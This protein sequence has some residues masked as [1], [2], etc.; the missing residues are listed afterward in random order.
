[1]WHY[2]RS[3]LRSIGLR[4]VFAGWSLSLIKDSFGCGIF[5]STFEYIKSQSYYHFIDRYYGHLDSSV[6][7]EPRIFR[8]VLQVQDGRVSVRP[9]YAL[10]P[11]FIL[12]AGIAASVA[13]QTIQHPLDIVQR[14]H[15]GRLEMLDQAVKKERSRR[16]LMTR[17]YHAY[18]KTLRRCMILARRAGGWRKFLYQ[19]FFMNTIRQVPSTSAGLIVF[20]LVRRKYGTSTDDV[21]IEKNGYD[22]LLG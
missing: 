20:E 9:H 4:G 16:G 22:I 8:P 19:G 12:L 2:S 14:I 17:Y 10:E 11:T 13:Q 1:M 6:T 21:R 3:K 5:F 7:A 18:G 15:Y